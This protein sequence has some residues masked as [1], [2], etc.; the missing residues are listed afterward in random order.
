M[1]SHKLNNASGASLR[2]P[3]VILGRHGQTVFNRD[4]LIMGHS[5][6][7]L[8]AEAIPVAKGLAELVSGDGV[9]RIFCSSLGRATQTAG[10]YSARLGIAVSGTD[11]MMELSCGQWEGKTRAETIGDREFLRRTWDDRPPDGESYLDAE[12]RVGRFI[13]DLLNLPSEETVLVIGHA[14]VN[15]VFLKLWLKISKDIAIRVQCPHERL[16][17]LGSDGTVTRID[18]DGKRGSGLLFYA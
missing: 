6:S 4:G 5:D 12:S 3:T 7:P 14:G 18:A 16:Y 11:A 2:R 15:R 1:E 13:S 10:I 8:T 17:L 9:A